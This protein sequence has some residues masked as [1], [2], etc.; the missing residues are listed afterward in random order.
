VSNSKN[1]QMHMQ[2]LAAV[3]ATVVI[4]GCGG[5]SSSSSAL[6]GNPV[7]PPASGA[8]GSGSGVGVG[9]TGPTPPAPPPGSSPMPPPIGISVATFAAGAKAVTQDL[10]QGSI[11]ISADGNL[12]F[13]GERQPNAIGR[14]TPLGVVTYPVTGDAAAGTYNAGPLTIGPDGNV[15]FCDPFDGTDLRGSF[16]TIDVTTGVS[17]KYRP[18]NGITAGS[19][20]FAIVPGADGNLWF[21]EYN[22]KRIGKF[23]LALKT[24][25]EYGPLQSVATAITPGPDGAVWFAETISSTASILGRIAIDGSITEF[26]AS[27]VAGTIASITT[28]RD[29]KVWFIKNDFGGP[30]IG[31]I[32]P[33]TALVK[34]YTAG[35]VGDFAQLGSITSGPDGNL[36]FTDYYD[37]LIG[38]VTTAGVITEFGSTSTSQQLNAIV[39]GSGTASPPSLW[40]TNP[41][42]DTIGQVKL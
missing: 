21:S 23:D 4:A 24:A 16:A 9:E 35:F 26:T 40:F 10:A 5:G 8:G 15:W 11:A 30:G 18:I 25:I 41:G 34:T 2:K 42:D 19:Q 20:A 17:T 36:W 32:D 29:G 28:G 14:M 37:G 39:S 38:R 12:W 33:V 7:A 13:T 3:F 1:M 27:P 31:N 6:A 22:G